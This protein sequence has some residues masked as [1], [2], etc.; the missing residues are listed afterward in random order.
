MGP[1]NLPNNKVDDLKQRLMEIDVSFEHA[2]KE[3][4]SESKEEENV[5]NVLKSVIEDLSNLFTSIKK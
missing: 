3:K 4:P 1:V 2:C 5:R